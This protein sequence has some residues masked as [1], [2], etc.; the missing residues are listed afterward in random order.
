MDDTAAV[1]VLECERRLPHHRRRRALREG[2]ALSEGLE[3]LATRAEVEDEGKR[4]G[5]FESIDEAHDV[6]VAPRAAEGESQRR[7]SSVRTR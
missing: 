3:D 1:E 5:Q 6:R 7:T 2:S 4:V